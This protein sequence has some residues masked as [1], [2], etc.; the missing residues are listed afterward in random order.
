MDSPTIYFNGIQWPSTPLNFTCFRPK[1][2]GEFSNLFAPE[3]MGLP[4]GFLRDLW[5]L[6]GI[7]G[8]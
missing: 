7:Y 2:R 8:T 4:D 5:D 6:L 3:F 1:T